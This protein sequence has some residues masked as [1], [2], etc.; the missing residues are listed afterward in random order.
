M[1][2]HNDQ[3][4]TDNGTFEKTEIFRCRESS[5][6]LF[7]SSPTEEF[8]LFFSSFCEGKWFFG[9]QEKLSRLKGDVKS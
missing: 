6:S 5:C 2:L 1:S 8:M 7:F 3:T 9:S 4:A